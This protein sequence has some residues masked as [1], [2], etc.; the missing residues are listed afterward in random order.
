VRFANAVSERCEFGKDGK[1]S[2]VEPQRAA[3]GKAT[4]KD[5]AVIIVFEDDRVERWTPVGLRMVVEHWYPAAGFPFGRAVLGI[6]EKEVVPMTGKPVPKGL[7]ITIRLEKTKYRAGESIPLEVNIRNTGTEEID[8]GM[9]ASDLSRFDFEVCYVGGGM[10]QAGRMP[11]EPGSKPIS[12]TVA[13]V[14]GPSTPCR[15][16]R[17]A[18]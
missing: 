10:T 9:C 6:A 2:V 18:G 14:A 15:K 3:C 4:A 17:S 1:A 13:A 11:R 7:Q 8:L 5:G 16:H 12:Q